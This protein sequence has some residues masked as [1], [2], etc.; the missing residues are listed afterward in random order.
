M[1][2]IWE[3]T[4]R[5]I[6]LGFVGLAEGLP[7]IAAS[8]F[9]GNLADRREKRGLIL[10]ALAGLTLATAGLA[11]LSLLPSP[12][13]AAIYGLLGL[14]ALCAS[15]EM[16][17]ASAYLGTIIPRDIYPK[18]AAWN[19]TMY[20][21]A[22]IIGPIAAGFLIKHWGA[23]AVYAMAAGGLLVALIV[24]APLAP[25]PP[26]PVDKPLSTLGA[27]KDGLRFVL[28][29]RI[30]FASMVLDS[31]SVLFGEVIFVLPVFADLLGVGPVGLGFLR[32]APAVGS[33]LISLM[34]TRRPTIPIRWDCLIRAV[35]IFGVCLIVFG[36][37]PWFP[38]SFLMLIFAGAADGASVIIRQSLYQAFTPDAYRGRVASVSGVFI[39]ASNEIGGFESGLAAQWMGT[40]PSVIFGGAVTLSTVAFMRWKYPRLDEE[41]QRAP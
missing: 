1:W 8:L 20:V 37:S 14:S 19:L 4:H 35:A 21:S 36:L 29:K 16:P 34:E 26:A 32:A 9:A 27:V 18:A 13:L 40:V 28:S 38:L 15:M 30:I 24:A 17:S 39:S 5:P 3:L 22:T 31:F 7:F 12:P 6:M 33:C 2:Q 10:I 11:A 25:V 41:A 23:A